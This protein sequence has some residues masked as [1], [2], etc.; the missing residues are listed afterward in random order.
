MYGHIDS[1][2]I[3]AER[4]KRGWSQ[5]QLAGAAGLGI[6][7]IQRVE[8]SG[9]ASNESAKCLAAVFEVPL[10]LLIV[11]KPQGQRASARIW[12]A[13]ATLCLTLVSSLLLVSRVNA[14]DLAMFVVV[15]T[16]VG[17]KSRMNIQVKDG[18]QTEIKL[19]KELRL[20]LMP[21]LLKDGT[22][23]MSAEL[24]GWDGDAFK[25]AGKPKVL[26]QM[27]AETKLQLNLGNGQTAKISI[28]PKSS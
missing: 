6:R 28:T 4:Q 27:D 22:V 1:K 8:S 24:Y 5:E 17:G 18:Q 19:E 11:E 3:K 2:F 15:G 21:K 20:L 16:D 14:T 13:A 7:T 23:L 12:A 10:T 25:L 26:M 9:I